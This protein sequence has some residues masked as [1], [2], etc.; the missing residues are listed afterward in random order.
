MGACA[1]PAAYLDFKGYL[2]NTVP[3]NVYRG[4]G[5][6]E[7]IYVVERLLDGAAPRFGIDRAEIRRRN[8]VTPSAMPFTTPTGGIYDCGDFP[9]LI[10]SALR[11]ADWAGFPGPEGG[12]RQARPAARYRRRLHHR[13]CGRH[14]AGV[15]RR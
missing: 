11:Y 13:G 6:L 15:R 10:E 8:L 7:D 14:R 2:S 12:S 3:I 4:V 5:R 1:V 9:R